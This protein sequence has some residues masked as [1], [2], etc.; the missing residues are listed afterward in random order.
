VSVTVNAVDANWNVVSSATPVVAITSSD[1][2]AVLP[3]NAALVLGTGS[4]SVTLKTAGSRTVTAT[5][6]AGS[7]PLS[8]GTSAGVVVGAAAP[9]QLVVSSIGQQVAGTSFS[10]TVTLFDDYGVSYGFVGGLAALAGLLLLRQ[11]KPHAH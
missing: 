11:K 3:S 2:A 10:V 5:D 8:A 6:T 9:S 7:S 4:F 1:S